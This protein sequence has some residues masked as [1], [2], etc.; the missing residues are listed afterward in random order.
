LDDWKRAVGWVPPF[1]VIGAPTPADPLEPIEP[2]ATR[3]RFPENDVPGA[4]VICGIFLQDENRG[5]QFS[6]R[7][8]ESGGFVFIARR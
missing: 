8:F 1:P 7:P 3:A 5:Q 2:G 6:F 4:A